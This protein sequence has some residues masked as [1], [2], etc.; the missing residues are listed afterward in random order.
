MDGAVAIKTRLPTKAALARERAQFLMMWVIPLVILAGVAGATPI[1]NDGDTFWHLAAGRW[2]LD[3]HQVPLTDPF[4]FTFAG[5]PWVAH[6]W[7]SEVLV[8]LAFSVGGWGGVMLLTALAMAATAALMVRWL[9]RWLAPL[10]TTTTLVIGLACVAPSLLAR[11]HILALP[12]LVAWTIG[13]LAARAANRAPSYWLVPL[14]LVWANLH[15]SFIVGLGLVG[16]FALEA[17]LDVKAWRWRTLLGWAGFGVASLV[18]ALLTPHGLDGLVFPI[19][20]MTMKALPGIAEWRSPDFMRL[21]PVEIALLTGVFALFWR[22]VRLTAVRA[23]LLLLLLHLTLQHVRQEVL[24]GVI[25][26]LVIAPSLGRALETADPLITGPFTLPRPQAA[27]AAAIITLIVPIKLFVPEMRVDGP[28][29]PISALN[30]VPPALARQPVLNDYDFGGYLIFKGVKPYIDGRADMYGDAFIA[31]HA[32]I[33]GANPASLATALT[34]YK[35]RWSILAPGQPSWP[36]WTTRPAGAGST[37]IATPWC[38]RKPRPEPRSSYPCGRC[39]PL[40]AW[41]AGAATTT[42]GSAVR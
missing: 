15:S 11:P 30:H 3:H 39:G 32:Q 19:K 38:S 42:S 23:L 40:A 22:G 24:L 41:M 35:I 21:E 25:G 17:A 37:P 5:R 13:L 8:A 28:T 12:V 10:S 31:D 36:L 4:S 7:L 16:V 26:P 18:A 20:V 9:G 14:M 33:M 27:L 34:R 6:E 1:L 2:I 29:A